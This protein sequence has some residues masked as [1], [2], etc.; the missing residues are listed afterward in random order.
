MPRKRIKYVAKK[1]ELAPDSVLTCYTK[2]NKDGIK[3]ETAYT[4]GIY[5]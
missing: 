5:V 1:N 3:I 4:G 2:G